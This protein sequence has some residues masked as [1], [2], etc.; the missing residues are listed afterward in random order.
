MACKVRLMGFYLVYTDCIGL[1]LA[2][3]NNSTIN[4]EDIIQVIVG[5]SALSVPVAFS[6]ES[7]NLGRTL[8]FANVV[9]LV[10]LS[11]L[12][13]N[14]YSFQ[15]IFQGNIRHRIATFLSRTAIDYCVTLVVVLVVLLAL[16]LLP[17]IAE[18]VVAF[19]R[20]IILAFPASMGAVV[21]DSFDKE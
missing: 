20:I 2:M 3:N 19:K 9:L 13:V 17:L 18:P 5:A 8:Q 16:N 10:L 21:V 1:L 14:L 15:N 7:W 6:E 12:F 11:L 4:F